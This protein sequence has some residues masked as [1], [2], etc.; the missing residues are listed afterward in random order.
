MAQSL[1]ERYL[2]PDRRRIVPIRVADVPL[3]VRRKA[4]TAAARGALNIEEA[5]EIRMLAEE[6]G[7]L[8]AWVA[9]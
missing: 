1:L 8:I 5:V 6:P 2:P 7:D 3:A 4:A 9:P